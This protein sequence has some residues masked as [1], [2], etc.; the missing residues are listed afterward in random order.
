MSFEVNLV[1]MFDFLKAVFL[2]NNLNF[3]TYTQILF[4]YKRSIQQYIVSISLFS[5]ITF[6]ILVF[7]L[8]DFSQNLTGIHHGG[9]LK[10]NGNNHL[11]T[12]TLPI[13]VF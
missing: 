3:R 9:C 10:T 13:V 5:L 6:S 11:F 7:N 1:S 12:K 8:R 4:A 2:I